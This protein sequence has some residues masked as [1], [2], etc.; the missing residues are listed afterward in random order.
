MTKRLSGSLTNIMAMI[1]M[2]LLASQACAGNIPEADG[3]CGTLTKLGAKEVFSY[4]YNNSVYKW[5][6]QFVTTRYRDIIRINAGAV[7][8]LDNGWWQD[9]G[10]GN[11][12]TS[13]TYTVPVPA[14]QTVK[15]AYCADS[16]DT[17]SYL[18]GIV[19]FT[20]DDSY[21]DHGY[22]DGNVPFEGINRIPT[23]K[24]RGTT[25]HVAY[26]KKPG[27]NWEDGSITICP[28]DPYCKTP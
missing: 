6:V 26:N 14:G 27:N 3:P 23:F 5:N 21:T 20:L 8:Y 17:D 12:H 19:T 10:N 16:S 28:N 24:N 2:P 13:K 25:A 4:L 18:R 7:K 11:Y 9:T 22:P 1:A 15:V